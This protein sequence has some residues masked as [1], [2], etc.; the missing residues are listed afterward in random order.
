MTIEDRAERGG[1]GGEPRMTDAQAWMLLNGCTIYRDKGTYKEEQV[2]GAQG[3][4]IP[5]FVF[6]KPQL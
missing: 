5:S 3:T 1:G 6:L 4:C 2:W